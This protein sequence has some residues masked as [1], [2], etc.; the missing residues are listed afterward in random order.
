MNPVYQ[1]AVATGSHHCCHS[2]SSTANWGL[3]DSFS[4][5]IHHSCC[6]CPGLAA[7][8]SPDCCHSTPAATTGR[9]SPGSITTAS[10]RKPVGWGRRASSPQ[11][12]AGCT[13]CFA[14]QLQGRHLRDLHRLLSIGQLETGDLGS[15][16]PASYGASHH[17]SVST[18]VPHESYDL[19][20]RWMT[21]SP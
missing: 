5:G 19:Q 6:N 21:K 14:R 17:V 20:S 15:P 11:A 12:A 7:V 8:S 18:G 2:R 16:R 4:L 3:A 10:Y 13:A 1:V 9:N